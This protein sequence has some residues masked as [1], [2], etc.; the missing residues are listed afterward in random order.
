MSMPPEVSW[1]YGWVPEK[2]SPEEELYHSYLRPRDWLGES[3]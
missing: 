1:T 3:L 2:D